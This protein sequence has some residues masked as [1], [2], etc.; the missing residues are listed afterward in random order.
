MACGDGCRFGGEVFPHLNLNVAAGSG[1][2]YCRND[3]WDITLDDGP[4]A[5]AQHDKRDLSS[6]KVLLITNIA[7]CR[8]NTSKP[9]ASASVMRSPFSSWSQPR[10]R[11]SVTV[12]WPI[13]Y[14]ARVRGVPLPNS[15]NIIEARQLLT[16]QCCL[17]RIGGRREPVPVSPQTR[18]KAR[19]RS[20]PRC[21]E[22]PLKSE[23][24]CL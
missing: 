12:C 11:A 2:I 5:F 19:R 7:I 15:T 14:R 24:V 21:S 23:F 3:L 10:A 13:R 8:F 6:G 17:R 9:A 4:A 20:C 16:L 18:A 22:I 1:C